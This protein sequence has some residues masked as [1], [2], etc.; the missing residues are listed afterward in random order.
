MKPAFDPGASAS[1]RTD[2]A[3]VNVEL[4]RYPHGGA[5]ATGRVIEILA[6]LANSASTPKIIIRQASFPHA[7]SAEV[8]D[9]ADAART[10]QRT[11]ARRARRL[12]PPVHRYHR[13]RNRARFRRCHLVEHR[14]DAV[15][16]ASHIADV[17]HYVRTATPLDQEARLRG[18]SVYFPDRAVPMLPEALSNGMCSL[19]PHE[20]RLV[21]SAL[22]ESTPPAT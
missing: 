8:L 9:E 10:R 21:M 4:L 6:V 2:G 5:S 7:F 11:S 18:T 16:T 3:V 19:K 12:P 22:M 14:A 15:G 17:A 20:D 1:R 13:R